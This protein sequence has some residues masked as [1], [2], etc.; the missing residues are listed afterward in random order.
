MTWLNVSSLTRAHSF[1]RAVIYRARDLIDRA[2]NIVKNT[3]PNS[4]SI[5][6]IKDEVWEDLSAIYYKYE[7]KTQKRAFREVIY[8]IFEKIKEDKWDTIYKKFNRIEK[9][10]L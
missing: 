5:E 8:E 1:K 10:R 6:T 7:D 3:F 2:N 4:I 9:N